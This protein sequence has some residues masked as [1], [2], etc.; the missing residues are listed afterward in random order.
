MIIWVLFLVLNFWYGGYG[1]YN[2]V[3][4][5][6]NIIIMYYF[7]FKYS[8]YKGLYNKIFKE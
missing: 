1:F 3:D 7:Y 6:V 2:L 5:F 8:V 4:I